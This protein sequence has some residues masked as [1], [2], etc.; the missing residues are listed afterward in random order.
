MRWP[1]CPRILSEHLAALPEPL[2]LLL[3]PGE[4]AA[5]EAVAARAARAL[6]DLETMEET[7]WPAWL[8]PHQVPAAGRVRAIVRRYGGALLADAVGLGKSYVA[9]AV[10]RAQPMPITLVVPAVLTGQWKALLERLE[11]PASLL[12]H[13]SLSHPPIR[14]SAH[15]AQFFIVDEA[16]RFRNPDTVRY[17]ALATL[18]VGS[19]V[20]LVTA[21]PVWNRLGDLFS[22]F[23]LFLRDDAL[24]A[25]GVRSLR[26]AAR[27]ECDAAVLTAV[28][29]RLTVAR[30]R[31]RVRD[32]YAGHALGRFPWRRPPEIIH[33]GTA[34]EGVIAALAE[35]IGALHTGGGAEALLRLTLLRRLASSLPAFALS[36]RRYEAF[37]ELS[38]T[39][40]REG[41]ALKPAEFQRLFPRAETADLQLA[42]FPLLL[43]PG[44]GGAASADLA[45]A[46]RL[47]ALGFDHPD[48]KA[49]TLE[50]LLHERDGKTIVFTE[51]AATAR[52]LARRLRHRHRVAVVLGKGGSFSQAPARRADVLAAFAPAAQGAPPPSPALETDVLVATDLLGEGLNLQDAVRVVHYDLPWSPARLAQ[53]VGR[54]DRLG[55]PHDELETV[56]FLP[57][58][59][60]AGMLRCEQRLASK[61]RRQRAAGAALV[62]TVAGPD[63][64]GGLDWCDRLQALLNGGADAAPAGTWSVVRGREPAVAL[65]LR[66]GGLSEAF[67]V[68]RLGPHGD[69]VRVT[70]LFE[71]AVQAHP[72]P[73][74]PAPLATAIRDVAPLARERLAAIEGARWRAED[75]DR[76]ARRLIPWVLSAARRAARKG[77]ARQLDLLDRL[78][79]R[80]TLGMTAGEELRLE[81]LLAR[82][83]ALAIRDL[84]AWHERLPPVA[85]PPTAPTVELVAALVVEPG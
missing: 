23:R 7:S 63:G 70:A 38:L 4:V 39:A 82:R 44:D 59:P 14:P 62:E 50:R 42:L 67:L 22:L 31:V 29:A 33:A 3:R 11:T 76:M 51:A 12:T 15:P 19:P 75:R 40:A 13:E 46:A 73:A 53:R 2:G 54:I 66:I 79:T 17:R 84:V 43:G 80:L 60:L 68:D 10:A 45:V 56:S 81:E 78:V 61:V 58:E 35:G 30:S 48:P 52:H 74:N 6:L 71:G 26:R 36:L 64:A 27:E 37:V 34:P 55:S 72:A 41:R 65:V 57:P 5:P 21:T 28:A 25:L 8:A 1:D 47:R 77:D 16:H 83:S 9:L 85:E 32:A 69:P 24:T 18:V 20:V 49:T